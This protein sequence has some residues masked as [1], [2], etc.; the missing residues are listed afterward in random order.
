MNL[1]TITI[2]IYSLYLTNKFGL[3]LKKA[4]SNV[5]RKKLRCEYANTILSRLNIEVVVSGLEHVDSEKQYLLLSNHRSIIDPCVVEL[6]LQ[7]TN[8]YGLWIAKKEL[9]FSFFF[10]LFVRNGGAILLD[11]ESKNMS[12]FFTAVKEGLSN[13]ASIFV[14]PEGTRNKLD[15][16]IN[17]FKEGSRII[18]VKN[19]LPILPVY[20]K[21]NSDEILHTAIRRRQKDLQIEVE[22]G[23]VIDY[24]DKSMSLED[25]YRQRFM[26][27]NSK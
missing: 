26:L 12:Q 20:I 22:I 15:T 13:G 19:R 9:Y 5:E 7:S 18:A 8:L 25:A 1:N 2:A 11:R 4:K 24:R 23:E 17:E 27:K 10:G 3:K 14:F 16:D 21:T 6:A